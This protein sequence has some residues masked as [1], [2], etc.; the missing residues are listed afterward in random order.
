MNGIVEF[1]L[2]LKPQ[3][4]T[5][6]FYKFDR[7]TESIGLASVF[8]PVGPSPFML[9]VTEIDTHPNAIQIRA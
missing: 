5:S 6:N 9:S 1:I 4:F 3:V 8:T 7:R 2:R